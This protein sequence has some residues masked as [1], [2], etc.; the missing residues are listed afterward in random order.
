M[1]CT[2]FNGVQTLDLQVPPSDIYGIYRSSILRYDVRDA[3]SYVDMLRLTCGRS[4]VWKQCNVERG[5]LRYT[6]IPN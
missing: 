1:T 2:Q 6:Q 4:M 3:S 5:C